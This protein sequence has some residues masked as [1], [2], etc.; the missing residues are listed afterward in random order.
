MSQV[1]G[2]IQVAATKL[3]GTASIRPFACCSRICSTIKFKDLLVLPEVEDKLWYEHNRLTQLDVE[4]ALDDLLDEPRWDVSEEHGG[5]VIATGLSELHGRL[6]MS[7]RPLDLE[8]GR[9][10]LITAFPCDEEY[11][12][13]ELERENG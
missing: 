10:S 2:V 9:W 11:W 13:Q 3:R 4:E 12:Q 1:S 6:F 7:L 8:A 5:R